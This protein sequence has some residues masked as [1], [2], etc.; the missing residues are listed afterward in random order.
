M[1]AGEL[2]RGAVYEC[3]KFVGPP[4]TFIITDECTATYIHW[5]TDECISPTFV[6]YGYIRR[7]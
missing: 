6:G 7:F 2:K 1:G 3:F 4:G 5:L